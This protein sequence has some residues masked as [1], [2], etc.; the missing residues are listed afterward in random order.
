M[1]D[2]QAET[3]AEHI[4]NLLGFVQAQQAVI[5]EYAGQIFADGAVQQH[6]GNGR[7]N[8]AGQAE[9][10]FIFTHLLT[11]T[12][13]RVVDDLRR[14]PQRFTLADVAHEA[15]QH[16]QPLT[17][18]GDFRVELY[19]VEAFFFI[20]H[21]GERAAFSAGDGHK[22]G[23]DS[24]DFITMAH[25]HVQQRLTVSAQRIFD[26]LDQRAVGLHF[27]LRVTELALVGS[28]NVAAQLHGHGLHA[29][30]YAEYRYAGFEDVLRRTRAV[31]F[32]GAFRAAGKN[33]AVRVELADLSFGH[34]PSPELAI[35]P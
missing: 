3:V 34:V 30:A 4:H 10:D 6:R 33:N 12:L 29:I 32:G 14:R 7:V 21:D 11:N 5:H 23:R 22:V 31:V 1:Y 35:D 28:F 19:A 9:D 18:V 26:A 24:G 17:G 15:L 8:A 2:V 13:N 16:T 20:R 27:H 25:P